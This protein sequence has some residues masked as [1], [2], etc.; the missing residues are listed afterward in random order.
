[1]ESLGGLRYLIG[2]PDRPP[3]RPGIALGDY[4]GG[5]MG[6]IGVLLALYDRDGAGGTGTG[7]GQ[8]IDNALYEAVMRI[9]EYTIS[10]VGHLGRVRERIGGGSVGTVPARSFRCADGIWV[11]ISA[12]NDAMFGRLA[13]VMGRPELAVDDRASTNPARIAHSDWV[14]QQIERWCADLTSAQVL[15]LLDQAKVSASEVFAADRLIQNEQVRARG[16]VIEIPDPVLGSTVM[17]NLVPRL[18]DN[19]GELRHAGQAIGA[20]N[21]EVLRDELGLDIDELQELSAQ[22]VIAPHDWQE[23]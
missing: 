16:S 10:A 2:E 17:Q 11:G 23:T 18:S 15:E 12:A 13:D 5:L 8:W 4:T 1:V 6:A 20:A 22:G 14:H 7:R 21:T 19:P 3:A 9:T